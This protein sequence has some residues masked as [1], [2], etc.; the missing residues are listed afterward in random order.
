[1]TS[2]NDLPGLVVQGLRTQEA[3]TRGVAGGSVLRGEPGPECKKVGGIIEGRGE[4]CF[5]DD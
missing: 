1:M 4:G 3:S 2:G 5:A